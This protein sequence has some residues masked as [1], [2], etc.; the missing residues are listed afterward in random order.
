MAELQVERV[1]RHLVAHRQDGHG[2][3]VAGGVG[4]V[5]ARRHAGQTQAGTC[6]TGGEAGK[7]RVLLYLVNTHTYG[8][9]RYQRRARDPAAGSP[10]SFGPASGSA[11]SPP[12]RTQRISATPTREHDQ[13]EMKKGADL[14]VASLDVVEGSL[15]QLHQLRVPHSVDG[16]GSGLFGQGLHLRCRKV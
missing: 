3:E 16:G 14:R 2:G 13:M 10:E 8:C 7:R 5:G 6:G 1:D 11:G 15:G 9:S 12:A 4:D